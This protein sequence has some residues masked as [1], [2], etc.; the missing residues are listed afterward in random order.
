MFVSSAILGF[1]VMGYYLY[2]WVIS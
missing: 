2:T 1:V